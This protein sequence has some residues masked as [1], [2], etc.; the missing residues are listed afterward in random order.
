MAIRGIDLFC[1]GGGSS[2]GARAAGVEMVGA[3]DAWSMAASTYRRNF[4]GARVVETRLNRRSDKA[5]LGDIGHIDLVLASPECTSHT[6]A[7]GARVKDEGSRATAFHVLKFIRELNPRWAVIENVIQMRA[8]ER[9][10]NFLA[11]LKEHMHVTEHVLDAQDFGAPQTRRRLFLMCSKDGP[12]D[13]PISLSM[14]KRTVL[15]ILAPTG[16]YKTRPVFGSG[17]AE[18]TVARAKRAID[19]LG[20]DIPFLIVYYSSDGG[21][22]WQPLDRPIRTL[23]T[24]DRFGLVEWIDGEPRMRMLQ[25]D[26]LQRAMGFSDDYILDQGSRR[27]KIKM[28][29]NGVCPT[30]MQCVV[31]ALTSQNHQDHRL[32][33]S[34]MGDRRLP[35]AQLTSSMAEPL[36]SGLPVP[37]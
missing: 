27:D 34:E 11:A 6:P 32:R 13:P 18:P 12:P 1:G 24:L 21:G 29:G 30:V 14:R 5:L 26:E 10:P 23:T 19:I 25:V 31:S 28:L 35:T 17:L 36:F 2:W 16:T 20:R 22:G 4:P 7:R 8:W 9:Y 3:V 33:I 15:D 37:G